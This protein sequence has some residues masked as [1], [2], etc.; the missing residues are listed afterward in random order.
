M[1]TRRKREEDEFQEQ[2]IEVAQLCGWMVAHHPDSRR[3]KGNAGLPDLILAKE[4]RVVF[5]ELKS[6]TGTVSD[7]QQ[8]WL[9]ALAPRKGQT[10]AHSV[11]VWRAKDDE[12]WAEIKRVLGAAP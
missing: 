7:A 5:A 2:I 11:Y 1:A 6:S 8:G 3:M 9:D 4:G 10:A 12:H